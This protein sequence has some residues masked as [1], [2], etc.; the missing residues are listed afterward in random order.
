[1]AYPYNYTIAAPTTMLPTAAPTGALSTVAAPQGRVR[2][3][4]TPSLDYATMGDQQGYYFV[5]NKGKPAKV[6]GNTSG[7]VPLNADAQ[8]R[9]LNARDGNAVAAEGAGAGGLQSVYSMAQQLSAEGGKKAHWA[10]EMMDPTTQQW[11]RVADDPRGGLGIIGDIASLISPAYALGS[12]RL[13]GAEGGG[14]KNTNGTVDTDNFG[15]LGSIFGAQLPAP[16]GPFAARQPAAMPQQDWNRYAMAPEQSFFVQP[17]TPQPAPQ[18]TPQPLARGGMAV[19]HG[20]SDDVP[21][22]LSNK[23]YVIDAETMALLGNGDPDA[24]ADLMDRWRV[25]VRKHKGRQLS[26]GGISPDA[27]APEAYMGRN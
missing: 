5:T 20:R 1:M 17:P 12:G 26:K 16:T 25:N 9:L 27:K 7:F 3:S 15:K 22:L 19:S 14:S 6:S 2:P 11:S 13:T 8:Y 21:A 4:L 10:V 18:P 23:E 24:G